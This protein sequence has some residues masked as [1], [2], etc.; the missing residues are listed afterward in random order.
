[1]PMF[2]VG[3]ESLIDL[4]AEPTGPD[5]AIKLV[6]HQGG[7]PYNCAIALS[8]LGNATGFLCPISHD[9]LGSYLIGPL[10]EAGVT[11]L[12][13][14]RVADYTTLAVVTFDE[15]RSASYGFYRHAD[16]AFTREGL[17]AALPAEIEVFQVGGF[18]PIEPEDA[19]V[20][21]DVVREA[22]RRGATLTMDPNV[23]PSLVADFAGYKARLSQFLD[24]VHLVK[25]S[26]EDLMALEKNEAVKDLPADEIEA[27]VEKYVTD[28]LS[29]P[30][31]EL[32]IVT[33]GENGS[34]A[35]TRA[36]RATQPVYPAIPFGDTVGAGDS[37]MAG[38]LTQLSETGAL[39]P[40]ELKGLGADALATMLHFGSV[41]AGINCQRVGCVPPTRAE[42]DAVLTKR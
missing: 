17:I 14:E 37:L 4:I 13:K 1:M 15:R 18:C 30:Y 6:A 16:R 20:W 24:L 33:F 35:Y 23:R 42:V 7:S 19:A 2:V 12:L 9:T 28:F 22:A 27:I 25:V 31:C 11:P 8:K 5:G 36:G 39:R 38:V 29:R 3:G 32:V 34:R 41:V 21:L 40:G 10:A 26:H